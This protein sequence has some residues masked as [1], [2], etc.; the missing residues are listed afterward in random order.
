MDLI[1]IIIPLYNAELFIEKAYRFILN[2]KDLKIPF[3]IIFVDNNS[4]DESFKIASDIA[5]KDKRVKVFKEEVQGAPA[6]RNKG[7][8]ESKGNYL[9]FF[10]V[11][12]QLFDNALNNLVSVL[13]ENK[14]I[15]AVFGKFIRSSKNIEL[16]D[17][18]ELKETSE[19]IIKPKPYWGLLWLKDLSQTV[20]PPGFLYRR[21]VFKDLGMYNVKIPGSEDTALD[22]E[23]GMRFNVAKINKYIYL[24]FKHENA[25]TTIVKKKRSRA[26]MQWPRLIYSH[27][28]Y[29]LSHK[30][31]KEYYEILKKL[32]YSSIAKMIHETNTYQGR[33][34]LKK[35]L[36][37]D[38]RPM[39][40]P[41]LLNI[42]TQLMVNLN[43][44]YVLK[45]YLYY[46][47]PLFVK[48]V[49]LEKQNK[50]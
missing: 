28:P 19:L 26:F 25:T 20:G 27:I 44:Q 33:K 6:A 23:L 45:V 42:V 17:R 43:N 5:L 11:D 47:M 16:L 4:I 12:D 22:I 15:D 35:K 30:N 21:E 37:N 40:L 50:N 46:L 38:I 2:Q 14:S 3:E 10:D 29:H 1:S 49:T 34:S 7:F 32:L 31:Q 18:E 48:K 39:K 8:L 13:N 24:Y 41:M 9:Y 36:L